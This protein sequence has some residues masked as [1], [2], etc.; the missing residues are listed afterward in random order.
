MRR[1]VAGLTPSTG[2]LILKENQAKKGFIL[3][4]DDQS[5]TRTDAQFRALFDKAGL[6]LIATEVQKKSAAIAHTHTHLAGAQGG[7]I[8]PPAATMFAR[9]VYL[10]LT[11]SGML[12]SAAAV[13]FLL[14]S[15]QR[16]LFS[17]SHTAAAA[18]SVFAR[19]WESMRSAAGSPLAEKRGEMLGGGASG[20]PAAQCANTGH[21]Q[22][23]HV[24]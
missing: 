10:S 5:V 17:A 1:C 21:G 19:G 12:V 18:N 23:P 7:L 16:H 24:Q 8:A 15:A 14:R 11:A 9:C 20:N 13:G 4:L 6:E 3:D 22:H 2:V